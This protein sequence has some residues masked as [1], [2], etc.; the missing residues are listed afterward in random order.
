MKPYFTK[1]LPVEGNN[2]WYLKEGDEF[3]DTEVAFTM[4]MHEDHDVHGPVSFEEISQLKE[5]EKKY[6]NS[7]EPIL[8]LCP[9]CKTFH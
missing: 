9:T 6:V 7:H 1:Y 3:D 4:Y 8:I 2:E 5:Y